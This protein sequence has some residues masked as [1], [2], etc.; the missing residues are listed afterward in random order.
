MQ[1]SENPRIPKPVRFWSSLRCLSSHAHSK[2]IPKTTSHGTTSEHLF[3]LRDYLDRCDFGFP[4]NLTARLLHSLPRR[5]TPDFIRGYLLAVPPALFD[6]KA[7]PLPSALFFPSHSQTAKS[8]T[9]SLTFSDNKI[10]TLPLT[11]SV[12]KAESF[13]QHSQTTKTQK[14]PSKDPN[15]A[16]TLRKNLRAASAANR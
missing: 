14:T 9:P 3:N 5:R 11:R 10:Q 2:T 12:H 13:V 7:H 6:P 15:I 1:R 16:E 4:A 8:K